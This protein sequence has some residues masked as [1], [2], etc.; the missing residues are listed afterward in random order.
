MD[1]EGDQTTQEQLLEVTLLASGNKS[2]VPCVQ[3]LVFG[4]FLKR[5]CFSEFYD[6]IEKKTSY[7]LLEQIFIFM[8]SSNADLNFV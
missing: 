4:F 2:S 5:N 1:S 6:G 8:F 7:V 3:K